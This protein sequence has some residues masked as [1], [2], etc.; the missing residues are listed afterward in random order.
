[1]VRA[2]QIPKVVDQCQM[3]LL[4]SN[5]HSG[6]RNPVLRQYRPLIIS[7]F[8]TYSI[9]SLKIQHQHRV[10]ALHIYFTLQGQ[11]PAEE[12]VSLL[13]DVF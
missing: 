5:G 10:L 1:M 3:N 12:G 8:H 11:F 4:S 7:D 13:F 6:Q 9:D 2:K